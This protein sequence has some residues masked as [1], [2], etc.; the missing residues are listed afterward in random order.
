MLFIALQKKIPDTSFKPVLFS[1]SFKTL[2]MSQV[3]NQVTSSAFC[4]RTL[5]KIN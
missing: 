5:H 1:R 2:E 4:S 3:K